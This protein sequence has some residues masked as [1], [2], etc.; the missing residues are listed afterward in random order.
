MAAMDSQRDR[1]SPVDPEPAANARCWLGIHVFYDGDLDLL[2]TDLVSEVAARLEANGA[3]TDLFFLRYWEAGPHLRIR[4]LPAPGR[5]ADA[6]RVVHETATAFLARHPSPSL[7]DQAGYEKIAA[8]F[9][10]LERMPHYLRARRPNNSVAEFIYRPET[11]KYGSGAPLRATED[12]FVR[13]SGLVREQLTRGLTIGQRTT[14]GFAA[15]ALSWW[16]GLAHGGPPTAGEAPASAVGGRGG[17]PEW[18]SRLRASYD[19]QRDTLRELTEKMRVLA[20]TAGSGQAGPLGRWAGSVT[21]LASQLDQQSAVGSIVDN[22]AHLWCNRLGIQVNTEAELRT[23][24][25][26][27]VA[28][29]L[30]SDHEDHRR[31]RDPHVPGPARPDAGPPT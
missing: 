17:D 30:G 21:T 5:V 4:V 28:A 2:I 12:H 9:A 13:C 19:R 20:T 10:R 8:E 15:L 26:W 25:G 22:C 18:Q 6:R 14:A 23:L 24:V 11:H 16:I 3:A 31:R 27:S 7:V 1:S 29:I